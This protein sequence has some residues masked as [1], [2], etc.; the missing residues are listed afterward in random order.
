MLKNEEKKNVTAPG[1]QDRG[2]IRKE[3]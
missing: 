1:I 3:V 2:G